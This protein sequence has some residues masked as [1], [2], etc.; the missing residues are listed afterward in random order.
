MKKNRQAGFAT[1]AIHDGQEPDPLTGA[2]N[3]PIYLTSTYVQ[4]GIGENKGYEYSRVSNPTRIGLRRIWR[5]W[6]AAWRRVYLAAAWR[7]S[8]RSRA[9]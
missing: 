1:R 2:V 6:K 7:R 8:T 5:R 9:C 3:V 4:Q